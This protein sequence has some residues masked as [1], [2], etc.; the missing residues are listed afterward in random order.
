MP[1]NIGEIMVK[2]P[3]VMQGYYKNQEATDE[4]LSK[5]GWLRTGDAGV[6]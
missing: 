5:D 4:I 1:R 6:Y 2:G 3:M